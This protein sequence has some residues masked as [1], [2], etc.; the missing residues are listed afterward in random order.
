MKATPC[1]AAGAAGPAAP[2]SRSGGRSPARC[3]WPAAR[4]GSGWRSG[5]GVVRDDQL[6]H[7]AKV[8]HGLGAAV[9]PVGHALV[10]RGAGKGVAGG[11][12]RRDEDVG[13]RAIGEFHG[14]AGEVDEHLLAGPV[15]L[16][17]QALQAQGV[18]AVVLAELA[19]APGAL[20]RVGLNVL[21]QQHQRH[22]LA[23][24]LLVDAAEVGQQELAR[25]IAA[26]PPVAAPGRFR[27]GPGWWASPG[28]RPLPGWRT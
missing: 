13:A 28:R 14:G 20:A 21:P 8:A 23:A 24:Q 5:R 18:A 7:A 6:R 26:R 11:P 12:Q 19:V 17:H 22:A 9:Q 25:A 3:R 15:D 16:P 4:S 10:R 1:L 27:S 2:S